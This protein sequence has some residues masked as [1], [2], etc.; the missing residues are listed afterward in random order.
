VEDHRRSINDRG[1]PCSDADCTSHAIPRV[2]V[3]G[4]CY[5]LYSNQPTTAKHTFLTLKLGTGILQSPLSS[6]DVVAFPSWEEV[7]DPLRL[8]FSANSHFV[9]SPTADVH[10]TI[11]LDIGACIGSRHKIKSSQ[12]F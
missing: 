2:H 5:Y 12:N 7:R 4:S 3:R 1:Y 8:E 6:T 10:G 9:Y 11:G